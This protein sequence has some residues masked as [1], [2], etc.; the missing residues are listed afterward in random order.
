M[1][2]SDTVRTYVAGID[3]PSEYQDAVRRAVQ[4]SLRPIDK[5]SPESFRLH[6]GGHANTTLK[7]ERSMFCEP[8]LVGGD[9]KRVP[10]VVGK[11]NPM[12]AGSAMPRDNFTPTITV[13]E[14]GKVL[15]VTFGTG[16]DMDNANTRRYYSQRQYRPALLDGRPVTVRVTGKKVELV[17]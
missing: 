17:H 9:D 12:N 4:T 6:W 10:F 5:K 7:A 13:G 14:D 2:L 11:M 1:R 3:A 16:S 15:D 8:T